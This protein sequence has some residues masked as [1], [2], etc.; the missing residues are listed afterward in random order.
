MR[1][2]IQKFPMVPANKAILS[3][4]RQAPG[5]NV[6]RPPLRPLA[7][8]AETTFFASLPRWIS[9]WTGRRPRHDRRPSPRPDQLRRRAVLA[10]PAQGLHQGDGLFRRRA[11][12]SDRRH[13]QHLQRLQSLPRDGAATH[14]GGQARRHA[15]RRAADGISDDIDSRVV[16]LADQ[17]VSAQPDGAGHRG[18]D[19]RPA[20]RRGRADRW[21]RQDDTGATDGGG[22][23]EYPGDRHADRPDAN[24]HASGRTAG[25]VHRLPPLL[26]A[27]SRRRN[28][29]GRNRR[30]QRAARADRRHLHGDGN[31][32][33]D[34]LHHRSDGD[35]PADGGDDTGGAFRA[36]AARRSLGNERGCAGPHRAAPRRDPLGQGV[37]Q[38]TGRA[39]R[40]RRLDQCADPPHRH[41]R[42]TRHARSISTR[43]MRSV[44]RFRCWSI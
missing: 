38:R 15:G 44:A 4:L 27:I 19:P 34:G 5:W 26:G 22:V 29:S 43:S 17:H 9:R 13:H 25:G 37:Q 18:N 21:L 28:R 11:R 6:V 1:A 32:E 8:E 33:H 40:D 42:A 41:R 2:A 31:G 12:T 14:R 24:P 7:D 30:R 36:S 35:E 20:G 39:A 3:E 16:R 10:V 23:G